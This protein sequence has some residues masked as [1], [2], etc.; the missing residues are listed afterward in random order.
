MAFATNKVWVHFWQGVTAT[1]APDA[2]LSSEVSR[3]RVGLRVEMG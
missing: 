3:S 2:F 1:S